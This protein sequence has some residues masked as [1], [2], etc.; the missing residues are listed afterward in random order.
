MGKLLECA[1]SLV[2][3]CRYRVE[4]KTRFQA[5]PVSSFAKPVSFTIFRNN[6]HRLGVASP[7][8]AALRDVNGTCCDQLAQAQAV[9]R[10]SRMF[11]VVLK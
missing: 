10:I 11:V 1:A 8:L 4:K 5:T 2:E 7:A 9:P 3:T 6:R